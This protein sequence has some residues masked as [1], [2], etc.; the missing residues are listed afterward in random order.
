MNIILNC[1]QERFR[2]NIAFLSRIVVRKDTS[3]LVPVRFSSPS[4]PIHF[5]DVSKPIKRETPKISL[6]PR[7][8]KR[9]GYAAKRGLGTRQIFDYSCGSSGG[10][11]G[12]H[13][14]EIVVSLT[15]LR[16]EI[17]YFYPSRPRLGLWVQRKTDALYK[18]QTPSNCVGVFSISFRG[19][20]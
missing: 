1:R 15:L 12:P 8:P 6:G 17:Q 7:D 5:G 14:S 18:N 10:A 11:W 4:R 3:R 9:F 2:E 16:T 13:P 19:Q 20:I